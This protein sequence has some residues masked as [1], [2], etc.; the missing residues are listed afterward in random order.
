MPAIR[1]T[2]SLRS[3]RAFGQSDPFQLE[4]ARACPAS[5][6]V[7]SRCD[8]HPLDAAR[9]EDPAAVV[10]DVIDPQAV[11]AVMAEGDLGL[12]G[13]PALAPLTNRSEDRPQLVPGLRQVVLEARRVL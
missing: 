4:T 2:R 5:C 11:P 10:A 3:N 1:S 13:D 7:A 8:L 12:L 9:C 6:L